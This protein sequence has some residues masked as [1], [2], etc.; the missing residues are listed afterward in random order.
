MSIGT[1]LDTTISRKIMTS[2]GRW[3]IFRVRS[4]NDY[5][6]LQCKSSVNGCVHY[7][8]NFKWISRLNKREIGE[9][10]RAYIEPHW[11]ENTWIIRWQIK[12]HFQKFIQHLWNTH[13]TN[14]YFNYL[15]F[16]IMFAL[17]I[18]R[19]KKI[20]L[21]IRLSCLLSTQWMNESQK[22]NFFL[23]VAVI[24]ADVNATAD[25]L[26]DILNWFQSGNNVAVSIL[27]LG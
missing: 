27:S 1:T 9:I 15:Q 10:T 5:H 23:S 7:K 20:C 21:Q 11:T 25:T 4:V 16:V 17:R 13:S 26:T 12:F 24:G 8:M 14:I 6:A 19:Q 3:N 18:I 22:N 2:F